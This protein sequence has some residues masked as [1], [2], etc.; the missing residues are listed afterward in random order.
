MATIQTMTDSLGNAF[1]RLAE[2]LPK[3]SIANLPTPVR[4]HSLRI[5]SRPV[6][7]SV[8]HDNLTSKKYG[9]NK[10]QKE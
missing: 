5:A 6:K 3:T 1:P 10:I 8:K 4:E 2:R 9:G 7:I